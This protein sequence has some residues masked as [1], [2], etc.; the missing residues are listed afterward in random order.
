MS[1]SVFII[2]PIL[3]SFCAN[4]QIVEQVQFIDTTLL[5]G[6]DDSVYAYPVDIDS[7]VL[8]ETRQINIYEPANFDPTLTYP[9]L[10]VMDGDASYLAPDVDRLIKQNIIEP[11]IIVGVSNRAPQ[12]IDSIFKEYDFDF[13]AK[14]FLKGGYD[15]IENSTALQNPLI[16][17]IVVN[18]YERFSKFISIEVLGFVSKIYK[19]TEDKSKWTLGGYSNGGAFVLGFTCDNPGEFGNAIVM[20]PAR[21]NKGDFYDFS[22]SN[23]NYYIAAG[24]YEQPFLDE[25]LRYISEMEKENISFIHKRYYAGH[26]SRMWLTFYIDSIKSIYE[27]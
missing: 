26:D 9:I 27:K 16:N 8:R 24:M 13:R 19:I 23:S 14:E 7:E 2:L 11:I 3:F 20:S 4:A 5:F 10:V 17:Q 12:D 1:R 25:S 6:N 22:K 18:R 21:Y 15:M